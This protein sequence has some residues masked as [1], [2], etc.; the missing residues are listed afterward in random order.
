MLSNLAFFRAKPGQ[1]KS[2]GKTLTDLVDPTRQE[3]GCIS[4]DL[5]QFIQDADSWLLYE[6]WR[7]SADLEA[8]M[9]TAHIKAFLDV[10]PSLLQGDIGLQRFMMASSRSV[11]PGTSSSGKSIVVTGASGDLGLAIVRRL[12]CEGENV[13]AV[14]GSAGKLPALPSL[15]GTGI[16]ETV[17]ADVSD[18]KQVLAYAKRAFELWGEIDGFLNNGGIQTAVR[19]I[20]DFPERGL[21]SRHGCQRSWPVPGT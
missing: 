1:T 5:H 8:H 19:P 9:Q 16:L 13:L 21:R 2:L 14:A 20:V 7:S 18:A 12:V 11:K 6:N 3:V 17:V 15:S 10:A 4:Y